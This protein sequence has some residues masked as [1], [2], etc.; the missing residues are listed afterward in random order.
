M[1]VTV[2]TATAELAIDAVPVKLA[3]I[4]P[5]EKLPEPSLKTI[6]DTVSSTLGPDL[7][8]KINTGG[9]SIG[10]YSCELDTLVES[11]NMAFEKD[12]VVLVEKR[13]QIRE[14]S[15]GVI[16]D[17]FSDL[18]EIV[19]DDSFRTFE[20]KHVLSTE[21]NTSPVLTQELHDKI[22]AYA[23]ILWEK[24]DLNGYARIDF[25]VTEDNSLYFN[26]INTLPGFTATSLFTKLWSKKYAY[27]KLLEK[28]LH[29]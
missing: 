13:L 18:A 17:E 29:I 2:L 6:V 23:R 21:Y 28:I 14:I 19:K 25:F 15:I 12:D 10:V 26:E 9:S 11:L 16:D 20:I 8:V 22:Y 4:V 3:V 5:A 7:I 27:R 24:C 1:S